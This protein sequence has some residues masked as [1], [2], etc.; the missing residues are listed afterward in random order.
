[1]KLNV[2][3]V[4]ASTIMCVYVHIH[5]DT[6]ETQWP[7]GSTW[8]AV[9]FPGTHQH[10]RLEQQQ[11]LKLFPPLSLVSIE[12][13]QQTQDTPSVSK[14]TNKP[15]LMD[16]SNISTGFKCVWYVYPDSGPLASLLAQT[17]NHSRFGYHSNC[18]LDQFNPCPLGRVVTQKQWRGCCYQMQGWARQV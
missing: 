11:W 4:D 9:S 16:L 3:S 6:T 2:L 12:V 13:H 1:M 8:R 17:L 5:T 18:W 10:K 14:C 15:I 7:H